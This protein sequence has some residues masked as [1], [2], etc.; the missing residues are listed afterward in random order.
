MGPTMDKRQLDIRVE[1]E[2]EVAIVAPAG[3]VDASNLA[4]FRETIEALCKQRNA[5]VLLDCQQLS[6][7]NSTSFGLLFHFHRIC[8]EQD[9]QFALYGLQEK[10]HSII[11]LLGLESVLRIYGT[12]KEALN[13]VGASGAQS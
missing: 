9:G 12:R 13:S 4:D 3:A 7:A 10:I 1:H 11:N 6:Y 8:R 2:G 5:R